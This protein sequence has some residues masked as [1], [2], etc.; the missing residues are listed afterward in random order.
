MK[1]ITVDNQQFLFFGSQPY[2]Y[3]FD[4]SLA[5]V[6]VVQEQKLFYMTLDKAIGEECIAVVE[7]VL[8]A[9]GYAV[10]HE[11]F[12]SCLETLRCGSLCDTGQAVQNNCIAFDL[13]NPKR[14]GRLL[15]SFYEEVSK[16]ENA[17]HDLQAKVGKGNDTKSD[18]NEEEARSLR[19][20]NNSLKAQIQ[21]L[22]AEVSE[23]QKKSSSTDKALLDQNLLPQNFKSAQVKDIDHKKRQ[24]CAVIGR[25][26][27]FIPFALLDSMP[28]ISSH[29]MLYMPSEVPSKLICFEKYAEISYRIATVMKQRGNVIKVKDSH[30]ES[31]EYSAKNKIEKSQFQSLKREEQCLVGFFNDEFINIKPLE[32]FL[33]SNY[34]M[35]IQKQILDHH[36]GAQGGNE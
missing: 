10:N 24:V 36:L 32:S 18:L 13:P 1:K 20:E 9:E 6:G 33:D 31:H 11:N 26:K 2:A 19:K 15:S 8:Q 14:K 34:A 4:S 21:E 3:E 22:L 35:K 29:V 27:V 17:I 5:G 16:Y 7:K 30:R 23:L 28:E 25:K 12:I